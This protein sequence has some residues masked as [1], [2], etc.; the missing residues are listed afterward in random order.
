MDLAVH[1]YHENSR[2]VR[3]AYFNF[4]FYLKNTTGDLVFHFLD[5]L[6]GIPIAKMLQISM[7]GPNT[8]IRILPVLRHWG[9]RAEFQRIGLSESEQKAEQI[10]KEG[11][12]RIIV[13]YK[14]P[15]NWKDGERA[16]F[17]IRSL[18]EHRLRGFLC[19]F[20]K[21]PYIEQ[22][23][24]ADIQKYNDKGYASLVSDADTTS[25][26]QYYLPHHGVY[27]RSGG[28]RGKLRVVLDA[29]AG[30]R[31]KMLHRKCYLLDWM[32]HAIIARYVGCVLKIRS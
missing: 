28:R 25:D 5:G 30:W 14:A 27:K 32:R 15:F 4:V 12:K 21:N 19:Q 13:G 20:D 29:A 17:N 7:D 1:F 26:G 9:L 18:A 16:L 8:C 31:G 11:I 22:D 23:Y 2:L 3:K 10:T 6:A 24:R